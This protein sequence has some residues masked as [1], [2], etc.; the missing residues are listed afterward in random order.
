MTGGAG[1]PFRMPQLYFSLPKMSIQLKEKGGPKSPPAL[2]IKREPLS[3]FP[4]QAQDRLS[5]Q[6]DTI[7][8]ESI[9][10]HV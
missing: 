2:F 7:R 6:G 10:Q 5:A 8:F 3:P 4:S 9:P 1:G